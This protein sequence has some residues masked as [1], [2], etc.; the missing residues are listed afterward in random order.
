METKQSAGKWFF[1]E[2]GIFMII[3]FVVL[4]IGAIVDYSRYGTD[5]AFFILLILFV[6]VEGLFIGNFIKNYKILTAKG[7]IKRFFEK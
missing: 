4:G 2:Y 7:E 3:A 5:L 6:A 1:G